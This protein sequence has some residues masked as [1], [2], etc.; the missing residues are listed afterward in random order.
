MLVQPKDLRLFL[1]G[2]SSASS[3]SPSVP[4]FEGDEV[5]WDAEGREAVADR[6]MEIHAGKL[7]WHLKLDPA[8]GD[9]SWTPSC[10]GS[11]LVFWSVYKNVVEDSQDEKVIVNFSI[12][13]QEKKYVSMTHR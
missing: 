5:L 7:T 12:F 9:F 6:N 13:I 11:M 10:L 4:R 1:T 2:E 8:K 3:Q